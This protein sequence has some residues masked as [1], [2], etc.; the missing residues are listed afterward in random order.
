[1]Y[2]VVLLHARY[3]V[4]LLY[5]VRG[6]S[7]DTNTL[8]VSYKDNYVVIP[9]PPGPPKKDCGGGIKICTS[10]YVRTSV[11]P[12]NQ[13]SCVCNSSY[14]PWWILFISIHSDQHDMKMTLK[15]GRCDVASFTWVMRLCHGGNP[16][17][18]DTFLW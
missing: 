9:P 10:P 8:L 7:V 11:R 13:K 3:F 14:T 15:I 18:R 12:Y 4:L 5:A 16:C 2:T 17:P 6:S 1:M